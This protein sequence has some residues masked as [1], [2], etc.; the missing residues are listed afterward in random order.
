MLL[1]GFAAMALFAQAPVADGAVDAVAYDSLVEGRNAA[2]IAELELAE[3][4]NQ[5]DPARLINLG[6]AYANQGMEAKARAMF[7]AAMRGDDRMSLETANGE[8]K[9]SRHLAREA[10]RLL[11]KGQFR[12]ER[13]AAR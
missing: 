4:Q 13:M 8:W 9:D 2:A 11:E 12:T 7:E 1:T 10:L 5:D 6:V 3:A